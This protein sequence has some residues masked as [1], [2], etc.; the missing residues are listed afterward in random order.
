MVWLSFSPTCGRIAS[1][2]T[3]SLYTSLCIFLA[4]YSVWWPL[5]GLCRPF[6][7]LRDVWIRTLRADLSKQARYPFSHPSP[8]LSHPSPCLSHPPSCLSHPTPVLATHLPA[9]IILPV[10]SN[11]RG[12]GRSFPYIFCKPVRRTSCKNDLPGVVFDMVVFR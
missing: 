12:R 9:C 3:G 6:V 8:C 5:L 11:A 7:F 4:G 1:F 2:P 10:T